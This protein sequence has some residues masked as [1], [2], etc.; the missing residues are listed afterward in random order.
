METAAKYWFSAA[1][2]AAAQLPGMPNTARGVQARAVADKWQSRPRTGRG[3]GNEYPL[4]SLPIIAQSTLALREAKVPEPASGRGEWLDR[5]T[6]VKKAKARRK[7]EALQAVDALVLSGQNKVLSMQLVARQVGVTVSTLYNWEAAIRF[8]GRGDWM[9][10]LAPRHRGGGCE[11]ACDE[12]A[13]DLI[14]ADWLRLERPTFLSCY[15]RL[16]DIAKL[17]GWK[18]PSARTLER[19][20]DAL[21]PAIVVLARKGIDKLKE[22]YPAQRRDRSVFHA[23]EAV[24]AD[25][26]KW[27]VFVKWP[28]GTIG[29]PLMV[30]FQDL[31]SGKFLSWRV[32]RSENKECVRLAFGDMV[33]RF[34][35]PTYC[36]LDNGRSFASK[37]LTA[38]VKNRFRFKIKDEDPIGIFTQLGVEIHWTTPYAGQSK[39]IER[40]FGDFARGL[41]KHPAFAGA[42]TGNSPM[43]KPENYGST[44]VPIETFIK[45]IG[46][47]IAQHN[48]RTGRRAMVCNGR[49]FDETFNE[50]YAKSIIR[51]ARP[52]DHR[53][54]LMAAENVL[55]GKRD[56][57]IELMGNR[58]WSEMLHAHMGDRVVIRFDPEALTDDLHVYRLDGAYLGTTP[59]VAAVGFND[60]GAAQEHGRTRKAWM[61]GQKEMLAAERKLSLAQVAAMQPAVAPE[62]VPESRVIRP[63]FGNTALKPRPDLDEDAIIAED[64]LFGAAIRQLRIVPDDDG[65]L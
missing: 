36:Y 29:R 39:P 33:E 12:E 46:E 18:I 50:S 8:E 40:A 11:A 48:A 35:I 5:Q 4:A 49:S 14:R 3:G 20:L 57:A 38:G 42:Y 62:A 30:A 41:A 26:H 9:A 15:Q 53:L 24:N 54:W 1:E 58:Y 31:Y 65:L 60:V 22:M 19:R 56:G 64:R 25:G 17:S 37:W 52:E 44:A 10:L 51:K 23:L 34:G 2:L 16:V 32:D 59:C 45:V 61:R 13:W 28:D 47:G 55:V 63:I 6:D 43:D 21:P 27:D 7:L